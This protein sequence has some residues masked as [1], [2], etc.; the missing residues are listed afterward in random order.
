MN[1]NASMIVVLCSHL[2]ADNC[3]PFEPAEW[4]KLADTMIAQELQ[5]KDIPNFSDDEMKQYF[6]YGTS[7]IERIKELLDRAG[8]LSFELEKLSAMGI[9]V[10]TRADKG[11]PKVLKTKLKRGCPPLFY[12]AGELALLNRRTVGFV[13]SRTVGDEDTDFTE[14]TVG[15]INQH[16]FGVVSGGAK[17]VDSTASAASL[18]N[19]SFCIEYISDSFVHKIKKKDV[20]SAIQDKKLLLMSIVKPDAGFNAGM[21]M[22]RNKFIYAQSEVTVV[23]KSDYNKGGTWNGANEALKK[24]YCPILCRD[25]KQYQGNV[26]LIKLGAIPTDDDWDGD[27][28]SIGSS[29]SG[30]GVQ[31]SM[32]D[33]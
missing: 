22:Q 13:G 16:G 4:T 24:K 32:F 29:I 7:E 11:Y 21:A 26:G 30:N 27:V 17:G 14:R 18:S 3:R 6:G 5:P 2:C 23:V 8:S 12:F 33:E 25:H 28:D 31:L 10:I 1:D 15:K 19:G 9:K 20:I